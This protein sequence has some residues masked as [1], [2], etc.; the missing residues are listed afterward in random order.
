MKMVRMSRTWSLARLPAL[1]AL[2]CA[3]TAF[4]AGGC[5]LRLPLSTG[6]GKAG[7]GMAQ[8]VS[9]QDVFIC[10]Q[11]GL[12]GVKNHICSVTKYCS[13]C[14]KDVGSGHICAM[15]WFC[16]TCNRDAG[17]KHVCGVTSVCR[18]CRREVASNH[19]VR[20]GRCITAFC[21]A[22][23][24]D[25]ASEACCPNCGAGLSGA[26]GSSP[27][28][29]DSCSTRF[30][31]VAHV[32]GVT[33]FCPKCRR[34]SGGNHI[35]GKTDFCA[36]CKAEVESAAFCMTCMTRMPDATAGAAA[37]CPTCRVLVVPVR[38][39]CGKTFFCAECRCEQPTG[40]NHAR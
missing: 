27:A 1:A 29:C 33:H 31:I 23:G 32:C 7:A 30:V 4:A 25:T 19:Q 15:T 12:A 9:L 38:H 3:V 6:Y 2:A 18:F 14:R 40:H 21:P 28:R 37:L 10:P 13:V 26:A 22:C 24:L 35:C 5:E 34:E 17:A 36:T 11:C 39:T 16:S 20:N 8:G